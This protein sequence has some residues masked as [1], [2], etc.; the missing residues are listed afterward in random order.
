MTIII[1]MIIVIIVITI[2]IIIIDHVWT[3]I[4]DG[5][6]EVTCSIILDDSHPCTVL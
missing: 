3:H 2:L 5:D 1:I 4:H 6:M